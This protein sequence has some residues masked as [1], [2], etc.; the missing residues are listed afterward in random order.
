[1][2]SILSNPEPQSDLECVAVIINLACDWTAARMI[3]EPRG[4]R[5]IFKRALKYRESLLMKLLRNLSEFEGLKLTFVVRRKLI[6]NRSLQDF[7]PDLVAAVRTLNERAPSQ[8]V[9]RPGESLKRHLS[10]LALRGGNGGL[11]EDLGS[12]SDSQDDADEDADD[13]EN[14]FALECLGLLANLRLVDLDYARV[15]E[16]LE[17]LPWIRE[18][19]GRSDRP[20]VEDDVLL[21]TIRLVGTVCV[22]A[23]AASLIAT[24]ESCVVDNLVGFLNC[25]YCDIEPHSI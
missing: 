12:D 4:I 3:G 5:M 11:G 24:S 20:P 19:L 25:E 18:S 16:E 8:A 17:L 13:Q 6:H 2:R 14:C 1:M 21:E 10:K 9:Q 23:A 15:L 7:L 22:D